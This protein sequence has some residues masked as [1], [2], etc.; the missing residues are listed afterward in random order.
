[1]ILQREFDQYSPR[2]KIAILLFSTFPPVL[3]NKREKPIAKTNTD[4]SSPFV[5]KEFSMMI[6]KPHKIYHFYSE[7][8]YHEV[9]KLTV[10]LI[11]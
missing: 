6:I 1:M 9:N 3:G 10:S 8:H 5:F 4:G 2:K 11:F 7:G